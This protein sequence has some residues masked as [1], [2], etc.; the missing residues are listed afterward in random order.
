MG[1]YNVTAL[2]SAPPFYQPGPL[3]SLTS[4]ATLKDKKDTMQGVWRSATVIA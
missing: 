2:N 4:R 3:P 1:S